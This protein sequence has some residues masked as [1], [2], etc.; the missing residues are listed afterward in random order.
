MKLFRG[1]LKVHQNICPKQKIA[2]PYSEAG[3]SAEILREDRQKH[4]L[5]N[6]EHHATIAS[7]TVLSLKRELSD[8]R[9]QLESVLE[10]K[11]VLPVT[12][13]LTSY[14]QK[15]EKK[16]IWRSP[17]FYT[18]AQG[19]KMGLEAE[20]NSTD[21]DA[22]DA[23]A[24][25]GFLCPGIHDDSLS[26]PFRGEMTLQILNQSRDSSHHSRILNWNRADSDIAGKP[27]KDGKPLKDGWGI[28]PFISHADLE[29]ETKGYLKNDC[30]YI[31][32]QKISFPKQWL[33]C[34]VI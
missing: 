19:Y 25:Y 13:S 11:M 24:L 14:K 15:K 12:F 27:H 4:M 22:K 29:K 9:D 3:C 18:H 17:Y 7:A 32:V 2:C 1:E 33:A 6:T 5:E 21:D 34:S 30:I 8:V 23:I 28:V 26:W 10:T 16:E 20:I 31:R